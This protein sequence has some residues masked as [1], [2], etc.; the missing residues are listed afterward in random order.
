MV[1]SA[2]PRRREATI[3]IKRDVNAITS[4]R[5]D[6]NKVVCKITAHQRL[7]MRMLIGKIRN[8]HLIETLWDWSAP[9][10]SPLLLFDTLQLDARKSLSCPDRGS[11]SKQT[12]QHTPRCKGWIALS[13]NPYSRFKIGFICFE[14]PMDRVENLHGN[15]IHPIERVLSMIQ[16]R[17]TEL[18]QEAIRDELNVLSHQLGVHT[19]QT[20]LG[21]RPAHLGWKAK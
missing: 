13:V 17:T 1:R 3:M 8:R 5:S 11:R 9:I 14:H 7:R 15:Q 18:P 4:E 20:D 6:V 21:T 2:L 16:R 12:P 19:N 10:S